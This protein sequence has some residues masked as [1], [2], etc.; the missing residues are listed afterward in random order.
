MGLAGRLVISRVQPSNVGVTQVWPTYLLSIGE[1]ANPISISQKSSGI[2]HSAA[3]S[4]QHEGQMGSVTSENHGAH[5][6]S[7]R[8]CIGWMCF[9]VTLQL[10]TDLPQLMVV[11]MISSNHQPTGVGTRNHFCRLWKISLL[12]RPLSISSCRGVANWKVT[13]LGNLTD[14]R[15]KWGK[16]SGESDES[17]W[18]DLIQPWIFRWGAI[19]K[20]KT[21]NLPMAWWDSH[22]NSLFLFSRQGT[23]FHISSGSWPLRFR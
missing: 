22:G 8:S 9:V 12:A 19:W 2:L 16:F 11:S 6:G 13:Q 15:E 1:A 5:W 20:K 21:A 10:S 4:H 3:M 17:S 7:W 23:T 18:F 14:W